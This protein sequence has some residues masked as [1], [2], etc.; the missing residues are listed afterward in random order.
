VL[1]YV[2]LCGV[3]Y[4]R[5]CELLVCVHAMQGASVHGSARMS[6]RVLPVDMCASAC[7][8]TQVCL[9]L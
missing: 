6:A 8:H 9:L 7:V 5:V 1:A 3:C 2:E 4:A